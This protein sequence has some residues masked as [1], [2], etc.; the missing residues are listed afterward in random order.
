MVLVLVMVTVVLH[1]GSNRDGGSG[2]GGSGGSGR[3]GG[4]GGG[5]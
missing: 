5:E 1:V 2:L 4:V 3:N